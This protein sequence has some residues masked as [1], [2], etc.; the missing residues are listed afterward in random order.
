MAATVRWSIKY[1]FAPNYPI[2]RK[3]STRE[4]TNRKAI[5]K[6]SALQANAII[7]LQ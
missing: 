4:K 3:V 7:S 6:C 1:F 5:A 2:F